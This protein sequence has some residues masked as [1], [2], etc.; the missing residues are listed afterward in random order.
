LLYFRTLQLVWG[1]S[2]REERSPPVTASI[3]IWPRLIS[4]KKAYY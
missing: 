1:A 2:C 4:L 3:L